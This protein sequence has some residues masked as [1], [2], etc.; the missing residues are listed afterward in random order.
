MTK[1]NGPDAMVNMS[2]MPDNTETDNSENQILTVPPTL[3]PLYLVHPS[4]LKYD[5]S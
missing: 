5:L 1:V 2:L 3:E 4:K